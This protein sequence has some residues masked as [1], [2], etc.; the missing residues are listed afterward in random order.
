MTK[1]VCL[2]R[3]AQCSSVNRIFFNL[4]II[5]AERE[6]KL[7]D[8]S[9][10]NSV[11]YHNNGLLNFPAIKKLVWE[12]SLACTARQISIFH[13]NCSPRPGALLSN[14]QCQWIRQTDYEFKMSVMMFD[15]RVLHV[16]YWPPMR[17]IQRTIDCEHSVQ[18]G[19]NPYSFFLYQNIIYFTF[20]YILT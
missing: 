8:G 18:Y 10:E 14:E 1:Q 2:P 20:L 4:R 7:Q 12:G 19:E 9:R 13:T 11:A 6:K 15:R 3:S 5:W 17:H 16:F